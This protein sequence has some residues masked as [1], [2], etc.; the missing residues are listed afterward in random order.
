MALQILPIKI[1]LL[2]NYST[3]KLFY[4]WKSTYYDSTHYIHIFEFSKNI[5]KHSTFQTTQLIT[6]RSD[7][8]K[9]QQVWFNVH[10]KMFKL[11]RSE[12]FELP[13]P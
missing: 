13:T 3:F 12:R 9:P 10:P 6:Q 2:L 7:T 11:V 8:K 5:A 1:V 4:F